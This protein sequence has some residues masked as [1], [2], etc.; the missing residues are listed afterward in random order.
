[1]ARSPPFY[2]IDP[3]EVRTLA[4]PGYP[5]AFF[6]L[7]IHCCD[8]EPHKR[9]TM[10]EVLLRLRTIEQEVLEADERDLKSQNEKTYNIGSLNFGGGL[11]TKKQLARPSMPG[12][13]PSFGGAVKVP[14]RH[15]S[16]S[17]SESSEDAI[18]DVLKTLNDVDVDSGT[19]QE[20]DWNDAST[21]KYS[22][23]VLRDGGSKRNGDIS[24][25]LGS[26]IFTIRAEGY[27]GRQDS[28]NPMPPLPASWLAS[29]SDTKA[30][31]L[32]KEPHA[33]PAGVL[34]TDL[35]GLA[36]DFHS[37][38]SSH[39]HTNALIGGSRHIPST[40]STQAVINGDASDDEYEAIFFSAPSVFDQALHRFSLVRPGWKLFS[41]FNTSAQAISQL[42]L[43]REAESKGQELSKSVSEMVP[44]RGAKHRSGL[45]LQTAITR[46][47]FCKKRLGWM[48]PYLICD[49]CGFQYVPCVHKVIHQAHKA[50]V[51]MFT[52]ATLH[53]A[54]VGWLTFKNLV[55]NQRC[56]EAR[57][58]SE[59][60]KANF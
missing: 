7:A 59:R 6:D 45:E 31:M 18:E 8:P 25:L 28:D 24:S 36:D 40:P 34:Q 33:V 32:Q 21:S 5:P 53:H 22:T 38:L 17:S 4:S 56:T 9:P 51:V 27:H 15:N 10:R 16:V 47:E 29:M 12:R 43:I 14:S 35:E 55:Q 20:E 46:C 54:R 41:T 30:Q 48:K 50:T 49:D 42:K 11:K 13:I 26:S 2:A 3:A 60:S 1:M 52:A 19:R 37:G 39:E 58:M 23:L 44:L 57:P